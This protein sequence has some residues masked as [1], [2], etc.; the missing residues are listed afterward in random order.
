I[1]AS[2]NNFQ[3]MRA[4]LEKI[5]SDRKIENQTF[6]VELKSPWNYLHELAKQ[7]RGVAAAVSE[8]EFS[9]KMWT[10]SDSNR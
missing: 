9:L 5:G 7:N 3:E 1:L 10:L 8:N 4:F 2:G 6:A